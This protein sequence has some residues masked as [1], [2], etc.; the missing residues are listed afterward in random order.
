MNEFKNKLMHQRIRPNKLR[1]IANLIR[2]KEL[3]EALQLLK[4]MPHKG[5][6]VIYKMLMSS[7]ANAKQINMQEDIKYVISKIEINEGPRQKRSKARARG[8]LFG[9]IKRSSHI[10]LSIKEKGE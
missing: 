4:L 8:R 9:I 6:D 10:L 1:R 3:L 5:S 2:N 7:Y